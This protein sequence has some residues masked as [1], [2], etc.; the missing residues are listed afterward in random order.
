MFISRLSI[1]LSIKL[2]SSIES[3]KIRWVLTTRYRQCN[4]KGFS[5]RNSGEIEAISASLKTNWISDWKAFRTIIDRL[6][7]SSLRRRSQHVRWKLIKAV[8]NLSRNTPGLLSSITKAKS[9]IFLSSLS[10]FC[11]T[12]RLIKLIGLEKKRSDNS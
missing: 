7:E 10:I 4:G 5:R 9:S 2:I 1:R 8:N 11:L 12:L 6:E 3:N